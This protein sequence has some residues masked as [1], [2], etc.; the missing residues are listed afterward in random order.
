MKVE[1]EKEQNGHVWL[2]TVLFPTSRRSQTP[3]SQ[4]TVVSE[5]PV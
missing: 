3:E 1:E 4:P 2:V 5:S